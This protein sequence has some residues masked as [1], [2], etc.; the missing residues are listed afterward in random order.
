MTRDEQVSVVSHL[1]PP[2]LTAALKRTFDG[3]V[4]GVSGGGV[5]GFG[6]ASKRGFVTEAPNFADIIASGGGGGGGDENFDPN[7]HASNAFGGGGGG[8]GGDSVHATIESYLRSLQPAA[9]EVT[10]AV[11]KSSF[12]MFTVCIA[13]SV[14]FF[15]FFCVCC[16]CCCGGCNAM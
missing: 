11:P 3:S 13:F 12:T 16:Y 5:G 9:A 2:A 10:A 6:G 4:G 15:F 1:L 8:G 7:T 14:F